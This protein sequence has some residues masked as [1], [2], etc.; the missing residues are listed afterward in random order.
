MLVFLAAGL[1][2]ADG[3]ALGLARR[4]RELIWAGVGLALLG[5][6]GLRRPARATVDARSA[7]PARLTYAVL[8]PAA[9]SSRRDPD[10][11]FAR[12]SAL[13]SAG[14]MRIT[15]SGPLQSRRNPSSSYKVFG[16][17]A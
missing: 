5:H 16:A 3:L 8:P 11:S 6:F 4:V 15:R 7:Q 12:A 14:T 17:S 1:D 9:A 10:G 2:P 13:R